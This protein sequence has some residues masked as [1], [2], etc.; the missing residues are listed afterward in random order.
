MSLH[1][2]VALAARKAPLQGTSSAFCSFTLGCFRREFVLAGKRE[3]RSHEAGERQRWRPEEAGE[4]LTFQSFPS[5]DSPGLRASRRQAFRVAFWKAAACA[6]PVFGLHALLLVWAGKFVWA[7]LPVAVMLVIATGCILAAQAFA[8]RP[9]AAVT[10]P[11]SFALAYCLVMALGFGPDYGFHVLTIAL[12]PLI[13]AWEGAG[14]AGRWS[15]VAFLC[16]ALLWIELYGFNAFLA[17][18]V[19]DTFHARLF[20]AVNLPASLLLL[21]AFLRVVIVFRV[22]MAGLARPPAAEP[23]PLAGR[24]ERRLTGEQRRAYLNVSDPERIASIILVKIDHHAEIAEIFGP[25]A[26]DDICRHVSAQI[27]GTV[28]ETDMISRRGSGGFVI[29]LPEASEEEAY[30]VGERVRE[31][32]ARAPVRAGDIAICITATL[33]VAQSA[34]SADVAVAMAEAERAVAEGRAA[35]RNRTMLAGLV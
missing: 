31:A 7:L 30:A 14:R 19:R 15:A 4:P 28:R 2:P 17:G 34:S 21:A 8:Q 24:Q 16:F 22:Q 11:A 6:I 29:F 13:I 33:G 35:G 12:L 26:A 3:G 10:V 1:L 18:E 23:F 27:I 5:P 25:A 20:R 32:V 9:L